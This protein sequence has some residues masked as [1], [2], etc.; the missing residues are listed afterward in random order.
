MTATSEP[1]AR[2]RLGPIAEEIGPRH[3][4]LVVALRAMYDK[5]A[6]S[7]RTVSSSVYSTPATLSRTLSG[8]RFPEY[9]ETYDL[10]VLLTGKAPTKMLTTL[11][12]RA[13]EERGRRTRNE[14]D[15]QIVKKRLGER[16]RKK[17]TA[18]EGL[19]N[20][21]HGGIGT[22]ARRARFALYAGIAATL[23][24]AAVTVIWKVVGRVAGA[25]HSIHMVATMMASYQPARLIVQWVVR[26]YRRPRR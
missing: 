7:Y 22:R 8:R 11:W 13:A 6:A 19:L 23:S 5:S 10:A 4:E 20:E 3:R 9:G 18:A 12:R 21:R 2:S 17:A 1:S 16:A 25:C 24:A 26:Q 14:I 15:A